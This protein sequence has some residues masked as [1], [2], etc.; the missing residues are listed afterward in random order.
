MLAVAQLYHYLAPHAEMA[1]CA[2][3]MCRLMREKRETQY[4]ILNSIAAI[5]PKRTS[6]FSNHL[7]S[8]FI[9]AHD[10]RFVRMLKLELLVMLSNETNVAMVLREFQTYIR[11]EDKAFATKTIQV[12]QMTHVDTANRACS[13]SVVAP[14]S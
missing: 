7:K 1:Q 9:R 2:K 8:F 12:I 10:P 13:A 11:D 3:A 6:L 5:A 14:P 4:V